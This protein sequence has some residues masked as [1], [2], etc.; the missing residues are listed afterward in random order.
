MAKN[1]S[2]KYETTQVVE[3]QPGQSGAKFKR[4]AT[5]IRAVLKMEV[6]H[7]VYVKFTGPMFVGKAIEESKDGKKKEPAII[8]PV[9]NLE[10]GEEAQIVMNRVLHS[11][12]K[13]SYAD[14]AYIGKSFEIMKKT[15]RE[16]KDYN[17]FALFEIEA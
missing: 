7:P 12:L 3:T 5:V 9:I 6:D 10:T 1:D 13:E 16:G 14:D 15:K 17:D 4:V 2:V 8:A 11:T